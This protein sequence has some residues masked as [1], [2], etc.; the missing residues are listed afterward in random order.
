MRTLP[1]TT[2]LNTG[3]IYD[4][5]QQLAI[6]IP[7]YEF[8]DGDASVEVAFTDASRHIKGIV[9]LMLWEEINDNP[10]DIARAVL[11]AYDHGHYAQA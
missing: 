3:R 6:T 4:G 2:Y 10:R 8:T 5:H 7:A 11:V 9:T 1:Q